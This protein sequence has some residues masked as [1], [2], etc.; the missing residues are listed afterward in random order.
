MKNL[1]NEVY[2][3][4]LDETDSSINQLNYFFKKVVPIFNQFDEKWQQTSTAKLANL[5]NR[6]LENKN[7]IKMLEN[8]SIYTYYEIL[9]LDR[10]LYY[11]N[12]GM[13][14]NEELNTQEARKILLNRDVIKVVRDIDKIKLE[15]QNGAKREL[16][17]IQFGDYETEPVDLDLIGN[18]NVLDII[19]D[20]K[21]P[22][23]KL[24][25]K[26]AEARLDSCKKTLLN[27][28]KTAT[29]LKEEIIKNRSAIEE[30]KKEPSSYSNLSN[31]KLALVLKS[32]NFLNDYLNTPH[33]KLR[34]EIFETLRVSRNEHIKQGSIDKSL[35]SA[36]TV[37]D[38]T[39]KIANKTLKLDVQNEKGM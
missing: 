2:G 9:V 31:F 26:G 35:I 12:K 27:N 5:K 10:Y 30:L 22:I 33:T 39:R 19:C 23:I 8:Q 28:I 13:T 20:R 21:F 34:D 4:Q 17:S 1:I 37:Y 38:L 29:L 25:K 7:Q 24:S 15:R 14:N 6:N 16:S 36:D 18:E 3:I 11:I 32:R